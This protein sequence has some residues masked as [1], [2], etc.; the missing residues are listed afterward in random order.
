MFNPVKVSRRLQRVLS[1]ALLPLFVILLSSCAVSSRYESRLNS[2]IRKG[3]PAQA[4]VIL[5]DNPDLY[6]RKNTLLYLL[7][8]GL[9][10]HFSEDYKKSIAVFEKAKLKFE[11]LYTKS[12]SEGLSSWII[13]D[14]AA[15]YRGEDF[16]RIMINVFQSLNYVMLGDLQEALVEARN[17]DSKLNLLNS[18]YKPGEK[19]VYKEDAFARLLMGILYE[20]NKTK[21]GYNDAFISYA[22]AVEIYEND[23]ALNYRLEVPEILKE[24]V[25]AAARFFG[26][27]EFYRYRA[28]YS[29]VKFFSLEEK[30]KKAE[31]FLIQYNGFSPVKEEEILPVVLPDGY[32]VQV[33]FPKYKTVSSGTHGARLSA[34]NNRNEDFSVIT[35]LGEDISAIAV[36][37]L[38]NRKVRITAKA[39]ASATGKYL[40]EKEGEKSINKK[41]GQDAGKTFKILSSLFNVISSRADL[42]SWQ[43]LPSQIRI[44]RLLL[45]PGEYDITVTDLD[46][47]NGALT[48]RSLGKVNLSGGEK[49]FFVI[50]SF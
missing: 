36:K 28:K 22:K 6:G 24:N 7:D 35:Q 42:R 16:E 48:E 32:V 39:I 20:A 21:E 25:L 49:K 50:R 31:V 44:A 27:T 46:A 18:R 47:Q 40:L 43:T 1:A 17:V 11:E 3:K 10:C 45:E 13:N 19:N 12:I 26:L 4:D 23:Y 15:S 30:A 34:K 37:N 29:G 5:G 33:A 41:Y 38:D 2:L 9:V 14:Y 8:K